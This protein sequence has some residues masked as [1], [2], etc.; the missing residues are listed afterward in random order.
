MKW[1]A[2]SIDLLRAAHPHLEPGPLTAF[3][4]DGRS[5]S[6]V[7]HKA[8]ELGLTRVHSVR[9][10]RTEPSSDEWFAAAYAA[11]R[12]TQTRPADVLSGSP[13]PRCALARRIA[14]QAVLDG[15][16]RVSVAGLGRVSGFDHTAILWS[17]GRLNGRGPCPRL[18]RHPIPPSSPL[19][20]NGIGET[21]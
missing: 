21:S 6:A 14:W 4:G 12:E 20:R 9:K 7:M 8:R 19:Y 11:A 5:I 15:N 17:L 16:P 13:K 10:G 3:A 1:T 18:H 2:E